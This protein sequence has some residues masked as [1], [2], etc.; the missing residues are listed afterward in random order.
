[1][2]GKRTLALVG[3][4][5]LLLATACSTA[6]PSS[7]GGPSTSGAKPTVKIAS[8]NFSES[9]LLMEIYAQALE[10]AGYT[11]ER[12]PN[13]GAREIV[14][15][16]LESG[17]IDFVP[18]YLATY[19]TFVTKDASKASSDPQATSRAL[20]DALKSKN[21]TALNF[22]PAQ[23]SNAFVVTKALADKERLKNISD[24]ARLNGTLILGGPPECPTRPFCL[25]G[26]EKTYNLKFK[27][28][29]ALDVGG[30]LTVAALEG[31]QIDVGLL[32][33]TD[34]A[35][36]VKNFVVLNDDKGLQNADNIIPIVRTA[37]VNA[38]GDN[39]KTVVNNVS[40]KIT[41]DKLTNLNK[42]VAADRK[43]EKDVAASF[44]KAEGL[45]K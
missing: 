5:V 40:A 32:F 7:P 17:Q 1:M 38:G 11:V 26:L 30:P 28:F 35:I 20:A 19:L 14:A 22:A 9:V 13:L 36:A 2:I 27:D 16:A 23:N 25:Q 12:K 15:P 18:E 34:P 33:S 10:N 4:T 21:L 6:T 41:T 31:K 8:F 29:K 43:A 24:L 3:A 42:Q 37:I 45:I 44:L 39:F